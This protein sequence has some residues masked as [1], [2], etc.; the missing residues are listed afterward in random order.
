MPAKS[1]KQR[2]AMAIAEHQPEKL[3]AKNKGM[4]K[5]S[6]SQL[7][8]FAKTKEKGLPIKKHHRGESMKEYAHKRLKQINWRS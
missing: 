7:D 4:L 1:K 2:M 8:D 6:K 5:M 3:H